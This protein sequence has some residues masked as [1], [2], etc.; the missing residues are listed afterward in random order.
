LQKLYKNWEEDPNIGFVMMKGSGRAFCAG[1]DI[2]S[3]YHLRTRGSPDAIREFFSSLYSFIYLLGTY[4]KPHVSSLYFLI[5]L[6]SGTNR[7][8]DVTNK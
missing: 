6:N 2:V 5:I 1:G 3:L 4:L 7:N 8:N